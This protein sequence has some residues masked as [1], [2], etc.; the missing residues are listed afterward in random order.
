MVTLECPYDQWEN[1]QVQSLFGKIVALKIRGYQAEYPYGVLPVDATDYV[2]THHVVCKEE[3]NGVLQPLMAYRSITYARTKTH[4]L[5]FPIEAMFKGCNLP[6]H[7]KAAEQ[8]IERCKGEQKTLSYD[9]SW[10][11]DPATRNDRDL[12]TH[13]RGLMNAMHSLYHTHNNTGEILSGGVLRFKMDKLFKYWGYEPLSYD[14]KTLE[15]FGL[16]LVFGEVITIFHQ[17]NGFSK[18][19]LEEAMKYQDFWEN[20]ILL[21]GPKIDKN[22]DKNAA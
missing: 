22:V 20:R 21:Q 8:I 3:N 9:S 5:P 13:L 4:Q 14:G 12:A 2:G 10:T 1:P 17:Q 11:I 19:S 15:S 18:Q 16:P 6:V 7:L